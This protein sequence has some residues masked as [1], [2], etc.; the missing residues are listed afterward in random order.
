M[1]DSAPQ[2]HDARSVV[3]LASR[4]ALIKAKPP[5]RYYSLELRFGFFQVCMNDPGNLS[6]IRA[7]EPDAPEEQ[8]RKLISAVDATVTAAADRIR[9]LRKELGTYVHLNKT[10]GTSWES[11]A[12][13][14]AALR[15]PHQ[16]ASPQGV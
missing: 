6:L 8:L 16:L 15:Y 13:L 5:D 3:I 10:A 9:R 1:L 2:I 4:V 12:K 7:L 11:L 14:I